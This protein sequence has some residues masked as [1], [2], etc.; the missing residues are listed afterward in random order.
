MSEAFADTVYFIAQLNRSDQYHRA[1][2]EFSEKTD[3]HWVTSEWVLLELADAFAGTRYRSLVPPLIA[4]LLGSTLTD[5]VPISSDLF[6]SALI[7]Y[8]RYRDKEW[9]LTDC[10]SFLIMRERGITEALTGDR[11]FEQAGFIAMLK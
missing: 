5:V 11:H 3:I 9:T 2:L 1:V 6:K 10:T 8:Q 7:F 4:H